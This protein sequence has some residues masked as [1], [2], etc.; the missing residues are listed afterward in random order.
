MNH[1]RDDPVDLLKEPSNLT[2]N[3]PNK[4]DDRVENQMIDPSNKKPD[5]FKD[6][7]KPTKYRPDYIQKE[8]KEAYD[9]LH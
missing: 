4:T 2:T 7:P 6:I 1:S 5:C 9:W 3:E 8:T